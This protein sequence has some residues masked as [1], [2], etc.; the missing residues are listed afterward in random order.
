M[1]AHVSWFRLQPSQSVLVKRIDYDG[2]SAKLGSI[3]V[4]GKGKGN[5]EV[6]FQLSKR[7][8]NFMEIAKPVRLAGWLADWQ[9]EEK[10][11]EKGPVS[12]MRDVHIAW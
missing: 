1:P 3:Y 8:A 9:K 12:K 7:T 11:N 2:I 10:K 4:C 5:N 6:E